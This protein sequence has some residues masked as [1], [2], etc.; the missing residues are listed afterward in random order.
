MKRL[1]TRADVET[2]IE[3]SKREIIEDVF[4][5][6]V[7]VDVPDFSALHD[8]RDAN[9]YGG[10]F[11]DD[12]VFYRGI[13]EGFYREAGAVQDAVDAWIRAGGLRDAIAARVSE[14][15]VVPPLRRD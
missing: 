6:W 13:G 11:E 7:P 8:Y 2:A 14:G 12:T 1:P 5:G 10:F 15:A 3:R 9:G 4:E